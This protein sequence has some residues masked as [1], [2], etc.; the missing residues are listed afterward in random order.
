[1]PRREENGDTGIDISIAVNYLEIERFEITF[2]IEVSVQRMGMSGIVQFL[3][4]YDEFRLFI[5]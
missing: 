5:K 3:F 4:L 2:H 1:M